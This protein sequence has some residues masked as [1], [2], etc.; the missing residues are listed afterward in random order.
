MRIPT[1]I[2]ATSVLL[3]GWLGVAFMREVPT[4]SY[5]LM[6]RTIVGS[7]AESLEDAQLVSRMSAPNEP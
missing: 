2:G 5:P 4:G 6:E 1:F 7:T 3:V